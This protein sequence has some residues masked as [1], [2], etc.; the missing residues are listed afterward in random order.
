MNDEADD[1]SI[2]RRTFLTLSAV[3]AWPFHDRPASQL[4]L[5]TAMSEAQKNRK[6][7]FLAQKRP[8]TASSIAD[9]IVIKDDN[10]FFI[11]QPDGNVPVEGGH[12]YGLY[13]HDC[14]FLNGY[15]FR[16]SGSLAPAL[17]ASATA[18]FMGQFELTNPD[19]HTSNDKDV[20][21]ESIGIR[22]QR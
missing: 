12:G 16:I 19:L 13:Y 17:G 5:F 22:W 14:R 11:A 7:H 15:E 8:T 3:F 21:K 2:S 1:R 4:L 10:V 18:G 20:K 6:E 9:A